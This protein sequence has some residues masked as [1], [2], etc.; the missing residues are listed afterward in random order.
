MSSARHEL[1]SNGQVGRNFRGLLREPTT[2]HNWVRKWVESDQH[3]SFLSDWWFGTFLIIFV[4]PYIGN[5][6]IPTDFH[7]FQRGRYTTNQLCVFEENKEM[8]QL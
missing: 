7:I 1:S 4:F 8:G 3:G 2:N 5:F 6:I